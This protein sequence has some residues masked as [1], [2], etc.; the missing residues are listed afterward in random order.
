MD[1]KSILISNEG[2]VARFSYSYTDSIS[3]SLDSSF[4]DWASAVASSMCASMSAMSA[5]SSL[6]LTLYTRS[7]CFLW[8]SRACQSSTLISVIFIN[9]HST[10]TYWS[11]QTPN[12][13]PSATTQ[14]NWTT[15]THTHTTPEVLNSSPRAPP[16]C[17]FCMSLFVNTPDSDNQLVRSALH[18]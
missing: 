11:F 17:I 14:F 15:H 18:A 2:M 10:G 16:L 3:S 7:S 6:F 1:G 12:I 13:L 8:T 9:A 4:R 5:S